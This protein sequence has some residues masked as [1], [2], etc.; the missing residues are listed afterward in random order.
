[1]SKLILAIYYKNINCIIELLKIIVDNLDLTKMSHHELYKY[2]QYIRDCIE[3]SLQKNDVTLLDFFVNILI[4]QSFNRYLDN[5]SY[6]IDNL[7]KQ[8]PTASNVE[9]WFTD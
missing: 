9:K 6:E 3:V 5:Y 7:L 8:Y 1:M 4:K 2:E